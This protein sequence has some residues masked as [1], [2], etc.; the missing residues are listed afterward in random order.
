M[1]KFENKKGVTLVM[2]IVT[3]IVLLIILGVSINLSIDSIDQTIDTQ[4]MSEMFIV[5]H[6][7]QQRFKEYKETGEDETI[8]VGKNNGDST[9]KY[10][11]IISSNQKLSDVLPNR[12]YYV[13]VSGSDERLYYIDES[14]KPKE[15][16]I[17]K[18]TIANDDLNTCTTE[19]TDVNKMLDPTA[20][21]RKINSNNNI[22]INSLKAL[23]ITGEGVSNSEFMVNY[24]NGSVQKVGSSVQPIQGYITNDSAGNP[25]S[26]LIEI[27]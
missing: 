13:A 17:Y 8:L 21:C 14:G 9:K 27:D 20:V 11:Y 6:A 24:E 12:V 7:V 23:G 5:Q 16:S 22:I 25:T 26:S 10:E 1:I 15:I 3:I 4:D 19:E 2:L 18:N